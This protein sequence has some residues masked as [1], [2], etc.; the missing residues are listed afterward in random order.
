MA[1]TWNQLLQH[2][3]KKLSGGHEPPAP[4]PSPKPPAPTPSPGPPA[5][6]SPIQSFAKTSGHYWGTLGGGSSRVGDVKGKSL[7]ECATMCS[8][9]AECLNFDY[10]SKKG[11]PCRIYHGA[12]SLEAS[13]DGYDAYA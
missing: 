6:P 1:R 12:P 5:P 11:G 4:P 2:A 10:N 3:L 13:S 8:K 9:D 7:D